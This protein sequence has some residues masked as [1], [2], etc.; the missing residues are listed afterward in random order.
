LPIPTPGDLPDPGIK[1]MSPALAGGFFTSESPGKPCL[2][3][4]S[5]ISI[6]SSGAIR[7]RLLVGHKPAFLS[8]LKK[9]CIYLLLIEVQLIYNVV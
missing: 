6:R 8:F 7:K 5:Q 9:V 3:M 4:S 1:P 2:E